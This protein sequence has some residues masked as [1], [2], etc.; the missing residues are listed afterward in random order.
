[1]A[2]TSACQGHPR[3]SS[4]VPANVP[5]AKVVCVR[6]DSFGVW[7]GWARRRGKACPRPACPPM[8]RWGRPWRPSSWCCLSSTPGSSSRTTTS[9]HTGFGPRAPPD[10]QLVWA[11]SLSPPNGSP[12]ETMS[13]CIFFFAAPDLL[14]G[15]CVSFRFLEGRTNGQGW[16]ICFIRTRLS[17]RCF[18]AI[19]LWN[20]QNLCGFK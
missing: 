13:I 7:R 16:L 17:I 12:H 2:G 8:R 20:R 9:S 4:G 3:Q 15:F 18:I 19:G 14:F 5:Q 1:M 6:G 11:F 10:R